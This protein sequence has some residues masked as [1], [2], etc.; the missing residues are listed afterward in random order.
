MKKWFRRKGIVN[1]TEVSGVIRAFG[2]DIALIFTARPKDWTL[3]H[4]MINP[5]E[6][7]FFVNFWCLGFFIGRDDTLYA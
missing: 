5:L 1:D 2:V 6:L 7:R 4:L 3:L